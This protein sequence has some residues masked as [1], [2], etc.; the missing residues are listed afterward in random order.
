MSVVGEPVHP[1]HEAEQAYLTRAHE[2]L[3]HMLERVERV[4]DSEQLASQEFDSEVARAHLE[5]RR[6]SLVAGSGPLCFGRIDHDVPAG[7]AAEHWYIGR[8]HVEDEAGDPIVVDWRA[9]V[10]VP[11]YRATWSDP[12]GLE[13]RRRFSVDDRELLD[14]LDEDFTQPDAAATGLGGGVPD[15][16]LAELGRARTGQMRDIVA[17]IQAE[18]D[19][20]IRAPLD[21]LVIVQGGPGTGKT[22][23]GL[24][25]AAF[26]LFDHRDLLS[27]EKV[28]VVGP[29][30]VFLNYISQVLPSLGEHAVVQATLEGLVAVRWPVRA[31]ESDET[32]RLKGDA[33]MAQVIAGS[34]L[35]RVQVPDEGLEAHVGTVVVRI[36]ADELAELVAEATNRTAPFEVRRSGL[37]QRLTRLI[38]QRWS[39][40]TRG[41]Q[42]VEWIESQLRDDR[43]YQRR[44]G[45]MWP[46]LSAPAAVRR[47]FS[48]RAA[49]QRAAAG[50][51]TV[52]ELALLQRSVAKKVGDEGWTAADIPLLD[53]AE[54][55]LSGPTTTYGHLVV[56]EAQDLSPMAY[57]MLARRSPRR[58]MTVLGDLAQATA[59]AARTS[60]EDVLGDLGDPEH[61][62]RVELGVGYRLSQPILGY[63]NRLLP[64]AAPNV[65]PST[66]VRIEGPAPLVIEVGAD[67]LLDRLVAVGSEAAEHWA[68]VG[69][70]APDDLLDP[71]TGALRGG[72]LTLARAG[73]LGEQGV[74]TVLGA[75][76]VKGLEFDAV[77]VVE[78]GRVHAQGHNGARL[79]YVALTRAVQ[80]LVVLHAQP[81]P[82]ALRS[83][84]VSDT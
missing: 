4:L 6:R 59:P 55:F 63:A 30:R 64:E 1:E 10:A 56:D 3:E 11:F 74:V 25:R 62:Q 84:S 38:H 57:R 19:E 34:C 9:T 83:Q 21:Q 2:L 46:N 36:G 44:L 32:A 37:R 71:V 29:N 8:R 16:L 58:S 49:R 13:R 69:V 35:D 17:T 60:W 75:H 65:A 61:A 77:V 7:A 50:L 14:L 48:N 68:T 12:Q 5:A 52:G 20:V 76:E 43:E 53:E 15:P 33:R 66:S 79:L 70:V 22:A 51:L 27:R 28:L 72:G 26:L 39:E 18:Q 23:V 54:G 78:P 47:L 31:T 73:Q 41:E 82:R 80:Q 45:R 81:L 24:H 67:Q 40:R 42:S